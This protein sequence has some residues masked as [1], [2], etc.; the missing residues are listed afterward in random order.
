VPAQD[1]HNAYKKA[2]K[3][4]YRCLREVVAF[5][6]PGVTDLDGECRALLSMLG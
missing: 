4:F 6:R 5:H 2:R 1:V 3:E